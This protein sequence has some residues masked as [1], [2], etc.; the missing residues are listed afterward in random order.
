MWWTKLLVHTQ[1][2]KAKKANT[3]IG[4]LFAVLEKRVIGWIIWIWAIIIK[5]AKFAKLV[6]RA[7]KVQGV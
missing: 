6:I 7:I 2:I 4:S 1:G 3:A 5:I